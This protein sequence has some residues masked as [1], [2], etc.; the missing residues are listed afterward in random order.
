MI[1]T[2]PDYVEQL[3]QLKTFAN[4]S[5]TQIELDI[6]RFVNFMSLGRRSSVTDAQ[7]RTLC[8]TALYNYTKRNHLINYLQSYGPLCNTL[9]QVV[10]FG[11][12]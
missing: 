6:P 7:I 10:Y 9:A 4:S 11:C 5:F 8:R 3:K 1:K 2:H 12:R